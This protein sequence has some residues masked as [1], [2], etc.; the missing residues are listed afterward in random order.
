MPPCLDWNSYLDFEPFLSTE[1]FCIISQYLCH[2][3]GYKFDRL[4]DAAT[5][6]AILMYHRIIE[7]FK[8]AYARRSELGDE[9][10]VN[11]SHVSH[12]QET[13]AQ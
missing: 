4:S 3:S 7:S 5:E 13:H 1:S 11:I 9:Q 12:E 6:K 10:F 2:I 8:F